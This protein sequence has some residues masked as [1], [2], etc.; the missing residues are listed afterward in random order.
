MGLDKALIE[1]EKPTDAK[2]VDPSDTANYF[3]VAIAKPMGIAFVENDGESGGVYV[4]EVLA[5]GSAASCGVRLEKGDQLIG[6]DATLVAG[7][8]FDTALDAIKAA[9]GDATKL[10]FYRGPTTFLY[11][12]TKPT[13]EWYAENLLA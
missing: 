3:S 5:E 1:K 2:Y 10:T 8:S 9:A 6:V 11:G 13:P 4:D 12:P 7:A